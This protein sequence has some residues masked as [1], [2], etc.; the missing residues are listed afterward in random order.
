MPE[1]SDLWSLFNTLSKGRPYLTGAT[2]TTEHYIQEVEIESGLTNIGVYDE[3]TR[4]QWSLMIHALD[5][6][7]MSRRQTSGKPEKE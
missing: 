6:E 3:E 1:L 4:V 5:R 2:V 7:L